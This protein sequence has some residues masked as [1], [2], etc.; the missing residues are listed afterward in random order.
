L[1]SGRKEGFD[2]AMPQSAIT[3]ADSIRIA[4]PIDVVR[5]QF[6]DVRHHAER[7]VHRG[8]TFTVLSDSAAECRYRHEVR[9][10]GLRQVGEVILT[11][12]ADGSQT[13]LFTSG[14]NAGMKIIHTFHPDGADATVAT[15]TIELPLRGRRSLL[16]ALVRRIVR[17]DLARGLEE[18]RL[19]LEERGYPVL[20]EQVAAN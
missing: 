10:A 4:R 13:N 3:V 20:R 11:R 14:S 6:G 19:D 17:R 7:R 12:A 2:R 8:V 1:T 18:D 5:Q 16:A 15:V 9:V